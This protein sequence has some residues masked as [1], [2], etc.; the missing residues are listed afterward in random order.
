MAVGLWVLTG[1]LLFTILEKVFSFND[2]ELDG[3]PDSSERNNNNVKGKV[4]GKVVLANG[5]VA[6]NAG[7]RSANKPKKPSGKRVR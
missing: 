1:M 5:Y 4:I 7:D 3:A 2:E 6:K